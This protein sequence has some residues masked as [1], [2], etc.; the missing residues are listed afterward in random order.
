MMLLLKLPTSVALYSGLLHFL[1]IKGISDVP[2]M[3]FWGTSPIPDSIILGRINCDM[4]T[5]FSSMRR[6]ISLVTRC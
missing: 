5:L 2:K 6:S 1:S 4:S 3:V